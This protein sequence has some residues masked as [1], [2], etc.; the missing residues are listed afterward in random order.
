MSCYQ[1]HVSSLCWATVSQAGSLP[2]QMAARRLVTVAATQLSCSPL[3]NENVGAA[4]ALVRRAADGATGRGGGAAN[5]I[6]LQEL[7][8]TQYF[9]QEQN[10]QHYVLAESAETSPLLQ[11]FQRLAAE[12]GVVR[13]T[14]RR[15]YK[16]Y[17]LYSQ[18]NKQYCNSC[19]QACLVLAA[20]KL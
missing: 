18:R 20:P 6:L 8:A 4:E 2:S 7:F 13:D 15:R 9:C 12:L 1:C 14:F 16:R 17:C 3:S 10:E 19:R 5:V 11:R